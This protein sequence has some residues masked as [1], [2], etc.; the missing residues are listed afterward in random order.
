MSNSQ[1][2]KTLQSE[3]VEL[4]FEYE[5]LQNCSISL[6]LTRGK[7]S[8]RQ[9]DLSSK[10]DGILEDNFIC[11]D[12]SDAR[13]YGG[14]YGLPEARALGG[15][16][17]ALKP[18]QVLAGGNSSLTLMHLCV[19]QCLRL[20]LGEAK[21]WLADTKNPVMLCPVPGYDRHFAISESLG[22]K[23]QNIA[24]TDKGPDRAAL[25][26]AVKNPDV[27][28]IWCVPKYSN[29]TGCTYDEVTVAAI[30]QLP[31]TAACPE[32]KVFWDNAYSVH[33]LEVPPTKLASLMS[34]AQ[35]SGTENG[36]LLFASTSKIT[37]AGSGIA[38][39]GMSESNLAALG[40]HLAYMTI[41]PDKV[42]QLRHVRLLKNNITHHMQKHAAIIKPK[43]EAVEQ[44][45][46]QKL[47]N[48]NIATWTKPT[49]GYFI[50]LDTLP[51]LA[52]NVIKLAANAGVKLT[53]AGATYP[54]GRD[55][56]D[57]NIRI[58][59]TFVK[60][61]DL[62]IGME[63]VALCIQLATVRQQLENHT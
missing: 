58:A 60:L 49:G 38:F 21:P 1:D 37:F 41:G 18:E 19:D 12:G 6:D 53:P 47:G 34:H 16:L 7:P 35:E 52:K 57:T 45:L 25:R 28:G 33:D 42:N 5:R 24:M 29:P 22:I 17:L 36:V 13:N 15:E 61:D 54:Y 62:E 55:P 48:R 27:V 56:Q 11:E 23:M 59:P 43:F 20:G 46:T 10:L 39:V 40:K 9:T 8:T 32:F 14:L 51:G 31:G 4:T 30:A 63:V 26:E 50:S 44:C 2:L 3:E